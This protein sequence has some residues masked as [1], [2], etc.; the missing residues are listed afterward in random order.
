LE[1]VIVSVSDT[2]G[3]GTGFSRVMEGILGSVNR[4][5]YH[6]SYGGRPS[7][8]YSHVRE[9]VERSSLPVSCQ[10]QELF[11]DLVKELLESG[12]RITL[13]TLN[14]LWNLEWLTTNNT[15]YKNPR[16]LFYM[17]QARKYDLIRW[18]AYLPVDAHTEDGYP[19]IFRDML[20]SVDRVIYMSEFGK[21]TVQVDGPVV[22]HY[23][24][25]TPVRVGKTELVGRMIGALKSSKFAIHPDD[26]L[27]LIVAANRRRKY[28]P[29]MLKSFSLFL[30]E[31]PA[32]LVAVTTLGGDWDLLSLCRT[33][34]LKVYGYDE[35][36]SVLFLRSVSDDLL[37]L[38]YN[39]ADLVL[40]MSGGEGFGLPQ[41]EAHGVGKPCVVGAYSASKEY[42]VH[43]S[44][45]VNPIGFLEEEP[46]GFL[47]PVYEPRSV[48]EAM[49]KVLTYRAVIREKSTFRAYQFGFERFGQ[50]WKDLVETLWE[51][52]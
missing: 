3:T 40:L 49:L 11:A 26:I 51:G 13:L 31:V 5:C 16:A 47:R 17:E 37:N 48:V 8:K 21:E 33:Y 45:L 4:K 20:G 32:K 19:P 23:S 46:Y 52:S 35:E 29:L 24:F 12:T 50:K 41:V 7:F 6:I 34:R 2:L 39:A 30:R 43:E 9:F 10:G 28:W 38:L 14:D 36:P 44:E 1:E 18:V 42:A 22:P 25:T 15:H 27:V